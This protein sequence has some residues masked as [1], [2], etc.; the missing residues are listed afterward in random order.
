ME[1]PTRYRGCST[2][3]QS[4][5][6]I[7]LGSERRRPVP[8]RDSSYSDNIERTRGREDWERCRDFLEQDTAK[9]SWENIPLDDRTSLRFE[10]VSG[11][12]CVREIQD[13]RTLGCHCL[14]CRRQHYS[15][16]KQR[17]DQVQAIRDKEAVQDYAEKQA[18]REISVRPT[19][20]PASSIPATPSREFVSEETRRKYWRNQRARQNK[21]RKL[22]QSRD[23]RQFVI[24]T[25]V[26]RGGLAVSEERETVCA[27]NGKRQ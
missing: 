10:A 23:L 12:V 22:A 13:Y 17:Y 11:Q 15:I 25:H 4:P 6:Y 20:S 18:S 9:Q 5:P 1:E 8:R 2:S 27:T 21:K 26:Y 14:S 7:P 19:T 24:N 16:N 3:E